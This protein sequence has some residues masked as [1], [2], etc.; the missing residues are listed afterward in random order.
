M[1]DSNPGREP[2]RGSGRRAPAGTP[3]WVK[4]FALIAI[5]VLVVFVISLLAGVRH[6]PGLH[7]MPSGAAR[8]LWVA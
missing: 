2:A 7:A 3:T 6:G 8:T 1:A 4:V 5:V